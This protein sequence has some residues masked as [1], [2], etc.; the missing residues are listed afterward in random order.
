[1]NIPTILE[2][3]LDFLKIMTNNNVDDLALLNALNAKF[4]QLVSSKNVGFKQYSNSN[5]QILSYYGIN[6]MPSGRQ[7]DYTISC[8]ND[9][10][11]NFLEIE[12]TTQIN[13]HKDQFILDNQT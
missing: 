10:L 9:H 11:L 12:Y 1:M 3:S 6:F 7:K 5:K 2:Q 8:I 4:S 13:N